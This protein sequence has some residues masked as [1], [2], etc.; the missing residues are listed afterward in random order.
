[1][2]NIGNTCF[3]SAA[4]WAL[5]ACPR[6]KAVIATRKSDLAKMLLSVIEDPKS[7]AWPCLVRN[8]DILIG[9]RGHEPHDSHELICAIIDKLQLDAYFNVNIVTG[10]KCGS[11]GNTDTKKETNIYVSSE[12]ASSLAAG[13]TA[14]HAP[15]WIEGRECDACRRKCRAAIRTVPKAPAPD[16][17]V[18]RV[19]QHKGGVWI[20]HAFGYCG[21][22]YRIRSVILYRGN[23]GGGHYTCSIWNTSKSR[24]TIHDDDDVRGAS[25]TFVS[26]A[27][28][29]LDAHTVLYERM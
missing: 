21:S 10:I 16:I 15:R 23:G 24:W 3:A 11:C 29:I 7:T 17:L 12:P 14:T 20:E 27:S 19:P 18:V 28:L 1:M 5:K 8:M 13:L 9:R 25:I 4:I 2:R 22:R 6:I 26:G